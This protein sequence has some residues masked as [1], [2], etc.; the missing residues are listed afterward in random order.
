MKKSKGQHERKKLYCLILGLTKVLENGL[1]E[2]RSN[3]KER[4]FIMFFGKQIHLKV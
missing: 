3:M 4:G 2:V 1:Q